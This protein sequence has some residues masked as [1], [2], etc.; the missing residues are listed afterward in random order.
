MF[1]DKTPFKYWASS[2]TRGNIFPLTSRRF[3]LHSQTTKHRHVC[4]FVTVCV[5]VCYRCTQKRN[6]FIQARVGKVPVFLYRK[7]YDP[8]TCERPRTFWSTPGW[9]WHT[10]LETRSVATRSRELFPWPCR[11][12]DRK[13]AIPWTLSATP[14]RPTYSTPYLWLNTVDRN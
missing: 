12:I 3:S 7:I 4:R 11:R 1:L 9:E 2:Y 6:K 10:V 13:P 5:C 14:A 8:L